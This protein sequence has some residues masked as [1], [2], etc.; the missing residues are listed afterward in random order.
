MIHLIS[1]SNQWNKQKDKQNT[2]QNKNKENKNK[3]NNQINFQKLEFTLS[4]INCLKKFIS[5]QLIDFVD[6]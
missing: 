3:E 2:K 4:E 5:F 1:L 6:N